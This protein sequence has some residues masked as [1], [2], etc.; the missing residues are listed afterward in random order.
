VSPPSPP[1]RSPLPP[2]RP[3]HARPPGV[4]PSLARS[5]ARPPAR[6]LARCARL[7]ASS[8]RGHPCPL[9][10]LP[11]RLA[12]LVALCAPLVA[13]GR[14]SAPS[15]PLGTLSPLVASHDPLTTPAPSR[16]L[17]AP[18]RG[19]VRSDRVTPS[20][21]DR[22]GSG[23]GRVTLS[24]GV[25]GWG[26]VGS[27]GGVR[28]TPSGCDPTQNTRSEACGQ[29]GTPRGIRHKSPGQRHKVIHSLW[30]TLWT[31]PIEQMFGRTG[32]RKGAGLFR[33]VRQTGGRAYTSLIACFLFRFI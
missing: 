2:V 24:G 31:T 5:P 19:R 17:S 14:P 4:A 18:P 9:S 12:P 27:R 25:S 26:R 28:P 21:S 32:V 23:W 7:V 22:I 11:P 29:K 33:A 8:P 16:R 6:P 3:S 10:P 1:V 20:G 13:S 15:P 30:I